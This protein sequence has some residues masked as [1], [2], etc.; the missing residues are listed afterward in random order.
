MDKIKDRIA[1][2]RRL[3]KENGWDAAVISGSDPHSDEYVPARW[4][5][6]EWISGFTGS[7]GDVVVTETHAGL[8]TDS[9]YFI[10]AGKE[11]EGS[12]ME[13]HKTRIP[14]AVYIPEWLGRAA[15]EK[16]G[17]K[18]GIDGLTMSRTEVEAIEAA[19]TP[20]GGQIAD[21]P[22]FI[23]EIWE[24]RPGYPDAP[25]CTMP[26]KFAGKSRKQ[27][28]AW[29]R[30][31]ISAE[32]CSAMLVT[33][34]DETAWLLNI[35][36]GD[37]NYNPLLL[38]YTVVTEN[39][40]TLFADNGKFSQSDIEEL[41]NDGIG[42]QPYESVDTYLHM[43]S[44]EGKRIM[45]DSGT[46]NYHL[47]KSISDSFGAQRIT[48]L[49]SPMAMEK[50]IKNSAEIDGMKKAAISDGVA[51][52]KFFIWLDGQMKLTKK[53][54][55]KVSE[56][57]AARKLDGLRK[58]MGALDESF[59][60]ISAYGENA[61]LPHYSAEEGSCSYLR[62]RGLYLV[63]YGGQYPWGTTDITRTIPLGRCSRKE[64]KGY[65]LVL[66]G[67]I[68]LA[69]ARFPEGT[70]G[71]NIDALARNP[72][73]QNHLDF[74]HGTGHGVGHRL[75]VHEGPQ[76]IRHNW[77]D[78]PLLPGMITSDEPGLYVEGQFGIRHENLLLCKEAEKNEFGK[79]LCFET[80]TYTHIDTAAINKSL[81][82][83][84]EI[85]WLNSYNRMVYTKLRRFLE[86]DE[87]KWLKKRCRPIRFRSLL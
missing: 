77:V 54:L 17:F 78:C 60:T 71:T 38:A 30:E 87:R 46:V 36:G 10:Q 56:T 68:A 6:R 3:M 52:T 86:R 39:G 43:L 83:D 57:D 4:Q 59:A 13:L 14:R 8:W 51:M 55:A 79:W 21:S 50:A 61:A 70:T 11:L 44:K 7:A 5:A 76:A 73:W 19:I 31:K 35:R 84:D 67:M 42:L 63:E 25:A 48:C 15:K 47:Y 62:P 27:K 82:S 29:L 24:D 1:A 65:T 49:R 16:P 23:S 40:C 32:N 2:L 41:Y 18:V 9:R 22:D 64:K 74:G 45:T 80:I 85:K 53:G 69:R 72:L 26:V 20:Y 58:D 28:L 12:G 75:C 34:L 81:L 66:K 33:A 37:I